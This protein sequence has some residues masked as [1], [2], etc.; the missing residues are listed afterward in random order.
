[1]TTDKKVPTIGRMLREK[2]GRGSIAEAVA[3]IGVSRQAYNAWEYG[4]YVP[5]DEWA[6]SL[7]AYLEYDLRDLVWQLYQERVGRLGGVI[8]SAHNPRTVNW[9]D[10]PNDNR[11]VT[12]KAA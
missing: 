3:T 1:M 2:R 4:L 11:P 5:G 6:E 9:V 8:A 7:A 10:R 12:Y